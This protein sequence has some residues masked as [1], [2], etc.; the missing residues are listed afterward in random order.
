MSAGIVYDF[1]WDAA[2]ALANAAK[3]GV[4][5]DRA[6]TVFRDRLALTVFDK[7]HSQS[8]ERWFTLGLDAGGKLLAVAHT[9]QTTGPNSARVRII[10]ARD[11]T[12][13]ERRFYEEE[14]R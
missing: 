7:A 11:A 10:S 4:T 14:P 2:K 8:E 6:A 5:F 9:Y 3:H 1:E 13:R 12:P